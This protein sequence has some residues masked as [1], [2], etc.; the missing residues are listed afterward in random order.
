MH[1]G[2]ELV[3]LLLRDDALLDEPRRELL[4]HGRVLGD[5]RGHQRLRVR[6]LVL[7]VVTVAPVADE[8]DDDVVPEAAP[9]RER[10]PDRRDRSLRVVG[11]DM[12]DR[13]V[14]ALREVARVAR[15][16]PVARIGREADLVVRDQVERAAGRVAREALRG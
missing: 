2:D 15:R 14:E 1:V 6:R 10:E 16:A 7:L 12:D 5:R 11:V 3:G 13:H 9:E 8:V 4:A